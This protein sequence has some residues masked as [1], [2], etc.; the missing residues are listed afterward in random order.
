MV[1]RVRCGAMEVPSVGETTAMGE[2]RHRMEDSLLLAWEGITHAPCAPM[3][4][5][6]VGEMMK[7][8][9]PRRLMAKNSHQSAAEDGTLAPCAPTADLFVGVQTIMAKHRRSTSNLSRSAAEIGTH[10]P[11]LLMAL[12]S[13]GGATVG[14]R[15]HHRLATN[16]CRSAVV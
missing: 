5:L 12:P 7:M 1:T 6:S 9:K 11:Y 15:H 3:A 10:A 2:H 4:A 14:E 16:S 13:A 8:D